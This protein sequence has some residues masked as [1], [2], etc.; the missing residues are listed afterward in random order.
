[1]KDGTSLRLIHILLL[2]LSHYDSEFLITADKRLENGP[3]CESCHRR[4]IDVK[5]EDCEHNVCKA[6]IESVLKEAYS[7]GVNCPVKQLSG[8]CSGILSKREVKGNTSRSMYEKYKAMLTWEKTK[9]LNA[10]C[11]A[12]FRKQPGKEQLKC[13]KCKKDS[14]FACRA[15][16]MGQSCARYIEQLVYA[17]DKGL[18][19]DPK[20]K[21]ARAKEHLSLYEQDYV[22]NVDEF[23]CSVCFAAVESGAGLVLR[24]CHH[25]L[26]KECL[27]NTVK[28]SETALVRCPCLEGVDPCTMDILDT[29]IRAVMDAEHYNMLLEKGFCEAERQTP[30]AFHC[31]TLNCKAWCTYDIEVNT[32]D[33]PTCGMSNCLRC[34]AIHQGMNC[35]QYQEDLKRRAANDEAAKASV[36]FLEN[37]LENGEAMRCPTCK[38]IVIKRSG[39][40]YM[41]CAS[42]RTAL[43]WATKGARW[44][45][46][47]QGDTS[48]GCRCGVN[49]VKCH[50]TCTT[51]H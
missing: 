20:L 35:E 27:I 14:C 31:K 44:G 7:E 13:P 2:L 11:Q 12:E 51:C 41:V 45:P 8:R 22:R 39:C 28:N 26:C 29:D 49:G 10:K 3:A 21:E 50:P 46:R 1:M 48:G 19:E 36:N 18:L 42:C 23:D 17:M 43:C 47:G 24:N 9:C 37:L 25:E 33:C 32:F 4:S 15:C 38:V 16:H 6:C 5:L 40:D 30:G 34:E